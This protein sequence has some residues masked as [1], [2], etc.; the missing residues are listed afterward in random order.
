ME[1]FKDFIFDVILRIISAV[2]GYFIYFWIV[3]GF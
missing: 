1:K 3:G 2:I